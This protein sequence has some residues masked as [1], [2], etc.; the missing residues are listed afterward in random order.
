[1]VLMC[2]ME[3][4]LWGS[5]KKVIMGSFFLCIKRFIG[6]FERGFYRSELAKNNRYLPTEIYGYVI[7][8]NCKI[9]KQ[10]IMNTSQEIGGGFNLMC[11]L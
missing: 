10:V 7:N 6:M 8:S 2:R 4:P 1:M 5:G 3:K 11:L 9:K